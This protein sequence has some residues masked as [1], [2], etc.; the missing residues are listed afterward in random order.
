MDQSLEQFMKNKYGNLELIYD[1]FKSFY[2][3]K[4]NYPNNNF[5]LFYEVGSHYECYGID[6]F[7]G[8]QKITLGNVDEISKILDF[9][10]AE[11]SGNNNPYYQLGFPIYSLNNQIDKINRRVSDN[12][13]NLLFINKLVVKR[14]LLEFM[15]ELLHL[16][17]I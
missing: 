10:I 1:Y 16:V 11:R 14:I 2:E 12:V 8:S 4:K 7:D 5:M 13:M 3:H 6:Y 9:K 15:I 17:P